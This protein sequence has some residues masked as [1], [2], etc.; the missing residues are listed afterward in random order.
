LAERSSIPD[1]YAVYLREPY[2]WYIVEVELSRHPPQKHLIPQLS[3]FMSAIENPDSQKRISEL[4][5]E[6]VSGDPAVKAYIEKATGEEVHHFLSKLTS[7]Q[8]EFV[9]IVEEKTDKIEEAC[10]TLKVE[11]RIVEFKTFANPREHVHLLSEPV[12]EDVCA[13]YDKKEKGFL[14]LMCKKQDFVY[15]GI[16]IV[17]HL[18]D[19][20]NI[21]PDDQIANGW[22]DKHERVWRRYS[23]RK[24]K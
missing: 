16:E 3:G 10:K 12:E 9:V 4:L 11:P 7:E 13:E 22:T 8:P 21:D 19:N 5:Y 17:E 18:R 6:K 15:D 2:K 24:K 1:G 20:H 23:A 14:C